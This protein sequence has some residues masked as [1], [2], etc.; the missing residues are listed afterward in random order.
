MLT[1]QHILTNPALDFFF[2]SLLHQL[3]FNI[4]LIVFNPVET[5]LEQNQVFVLLQWLYKI[6]WYEVDW[7][8]IS[9][10]GTDLCDIGSV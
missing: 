10:V 3:Q 5:V 2:G 1:L 9:S 7:F 8:A 4:S 6:T